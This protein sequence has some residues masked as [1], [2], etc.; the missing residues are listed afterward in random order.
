MS[1]PDR[2][3]PQYV[4]PAELR[5]GPIRHDSLPPELLEPIEA[6]YGVIGRY[7]GTSLE[8]FEIGFLWD[9]HPE[10]EVAIWCSITSAWLA[11]HEKHLGSETLPDGEE[12]KLLGALIAIS[13]GVNDPAMLNVPP[14]VG[15]R[16]L[17][18]YGDLAESGSPTEVE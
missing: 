11:Y 18:C 1:D 13:T 4:D 3:V 5:I 9:M 16:L 8:Q 17:T 7:L 14:E 2:G 6:V 15:R 12:K 10:R